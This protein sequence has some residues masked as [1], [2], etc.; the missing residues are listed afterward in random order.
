MKK[1]LA[2]LLAL[3]MILSF[4]ACGTKKEEQ[5]AEEVKDVYPSKSL[6]CIVPWAAGGSSDVSVRLIASVIP[7]YLGQGIVVDNQPGGSAIP[8]TQAMADAEPDGYH[9][10]MNTNASFILRPLL[11]EVTYK[12]DDFTFICGFANQRTVIAV[13]ADSPFQTINDLI[14]YAKA[15]PGKLKFAGSNVA[16]GQ[17]LV[18]AYLAKEIGSEFV[19]YPTS[20]GA[21]SVTVL[22]GHNADF[23]IFQA[24]EGLSAYK[25]GQIRYLCLMDDTKS[26]TTPDVPLIGECIPELAKCFVPYSSVLVCPKDVPADIVAK[27]REAMQGVCKDEAFLKLCSNNGIEVQYTDGDDWKAQQVALYSLFEELV[28]V[29]KK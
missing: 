29:I 27:L 11:T 3:A 22:L 1:V 26:T 13:P 6:T 20:G 2:I 9:I 5:K 23:G 18:G 24:G 28:P 10:G 7:G 16:S 12:M 4:A 17:H 19:H 14:D 25:G 8:G 21:E 15:N